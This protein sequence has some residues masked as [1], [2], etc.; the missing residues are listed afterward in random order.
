MRI[1]VVL[2]T[3]LLAAACSLPVETFRATAYSEIARVQMANGDRAGARETADRAVATIEKME[4]QDD[5]IFGI[6]AAAV[7]QVRAGDLDSAIK[8]VELAKDGEGRVVAFTGLALALID[9]GHKPKAEDAALKALEA[10]RRIESESKKDDM[11]VNAAWAQAVTGDIAGARKQADGFTREKHRNGL[12]SLIAQAQLNAGDITG[13]RTTAD[14][15]TIQEGQSDSDVWAFGMLFNGI[16]VDSF[17]VLKT[18]LFESKMPLKAVVTTRIGAAQF[19]A[20]DADEAR[21][22]FLAAMQYAG[23]A[24]SIGDRVRSVSNIALARARAGDLSGAIESLNY[25]ERLADE[26]VSEN[27]GGGA[28]QSRDYAMTLRVAISGRGSPDDLLRDLGDI[29][30]NSTETLVAVALARTLMGRTER[31]GEFL[32]AAVMSMPR[33]NDLSLVAA[34]YGTLAD[35]LYRQGDRAGGRAAA[36]RTLEIAELVPAESEDRVIGLFFASVALAR[37]GDVDLALEAAGRI[38]DP[39]AKSQ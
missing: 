28:G 13:A 31:A 6:P 17:M 35:T 22:S 39:K 36:K 32:E 14:S 2:L 1:G 37:T 15:I 10:A 34:A 11:L 8:T 16:A 18:L 20:G 7:A 9:T 38:E 3:G 25:A 30:Q 27:E 23:M 19:R 12:L 29:G 5:R 26:H 21:Q 4:G 24:R 33:G